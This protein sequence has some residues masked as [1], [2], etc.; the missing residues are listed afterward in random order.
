[1]TPP[2][3]TNKRS[4]IKQVGDL[5]ANESHL[6]FISHLSLMFLMTTDQIWLTV[7]AEDKANAKQGRTEIQNRHLLN[8][9]IRE[10]FLTRITCR[11]LN[12]SSKETG[13]TVQIITV[14]AFPP[15]EFCKILVSLLSL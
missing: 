6:Y 8:I 15:S 5:Q 11:V 12:V 9:Q 14:L 7:E 13:V 2:P 4:Q 3:A 1:M 10:L